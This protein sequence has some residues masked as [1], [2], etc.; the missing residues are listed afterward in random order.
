MTGVKLGVQPG[1]IGPSYKRQMKNPA[2]K[3]YY[4]KNKLEIRAKAKERY[5]NN[6]NGI[7][8]TLTRAR[9]KKV[10]GFSVEQ[11]ELLIVQQQGKCWICQAPEIDLGRKL[12]IDHDHETGEVRGLLCQKCNSGIGYF[13]DNKVLLERALTYLRVDTNMRKKIDMLN[14][15]FDYLK[16]RNDILQFLKDEK[17][18]DD[19]LMQNILH[20]HHTQHATRIAGMLDELQRADKLQLVDYEWQI[21]PKELVKLTLISKNSKKDFTYSV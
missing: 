8:E 10:Y 20:E 14:K 21:L 1:K 11:R 9:F 18:I 4:E 17:I 3:R 13:N 7:K 15:L 6:T 5:A 2:A 12:S 16:C 19:N